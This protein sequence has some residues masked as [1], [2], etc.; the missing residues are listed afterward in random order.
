LTQLTGF[1]EAFFYPHV[2]K[3]IYYGWKKPTPELQCQESSGC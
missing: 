2:E 1:L 3:E